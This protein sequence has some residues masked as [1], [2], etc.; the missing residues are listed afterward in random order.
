[1][2]LRR[3]LFIF[4]AFGIAQ[5][6]A[7]TTGGE[8]LLFGFCRGVEDDRAVFAG[9]VPA[10]RGVE[11]EALFVAV[12]NEFELLV[13]G[14]LEK[15]LLGGKSAGGREKAEHQEN[16]EQSESIHGTGLI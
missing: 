10:V 8:T 4:I 1:M 13:P 15:V 11:F 14:T 3:D 7:E 12:K 6:L 5:G 16:N 9:V 2:F